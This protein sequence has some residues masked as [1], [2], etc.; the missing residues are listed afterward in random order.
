MGSKQAVGSIP[1][2][3]QNSERIVTEVNNSLFGS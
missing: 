1:P 2:V 3:D